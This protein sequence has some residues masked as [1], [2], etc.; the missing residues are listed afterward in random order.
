MGSHL[1]IDVTATKPCKGLPTTEGAISRLRIFGPTP[2]EVDVPLVADAQ[3]PHLLTANVVPADDT[4][5]FSI[6]LVDDRGVHSQ[7]PA[8]YRMDMIPDRAP[9]VRIY[10]PDRKEILCTVSS[11]PIIGFVAEDDYG[12]GNIMLHYKVNDGPVQTLA[13]PYAQTDETTGLRRRALR[14]LYRW[15]LSAIPAPAGKPS[16]EGSVIEYWIECLDNKEPAANSTN[17][18]HFTA[19]VVSKA[20]KSRRKLWECLTKPSTTYALNKTKSSD[21]KEL[22]Q[23]IRHSGLHHAAHPGHSRPAS[24][25]PN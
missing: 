10:H 17:T 11:N 1:R 23:A 16:L 2:K 14:A 22:L 19:H 4:T 3:N 18:E 5:G 9:Q 15:P 25:K 8:V 13:I 24:P 7:D 21:N 20:E 6:D 12:L